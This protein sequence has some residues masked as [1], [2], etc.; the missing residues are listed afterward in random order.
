MTAQEYLEQIMEAEHNGG[1]RAV[2]FIVF[3]QVDRVRIANYIRNEGYRVETRV[4]M[5]TVWL[6]RAKA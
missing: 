1:V 2:K 5:V 3:D 4:C 6:K